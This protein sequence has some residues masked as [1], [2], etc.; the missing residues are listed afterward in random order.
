VVFAALV[1]GYGVLSALIGGAPPADTPLDSQ[2][3]APTGTMALAEILRNRGVTVRAGDDVKA[4]LG[5]TS[6]TAGPARTVVVVKP[7]RLSEATLRRLSSE[8]A[9]GLDLVLVEPDSAVLDAL[10]VPVRTEDESLSDSGSQDPHC[11]LPEADIAGSATIAANTRYGPLDGDTGAT[12][13]FCYRSGPKD[14]ALVVVTPAESAGRIVVLGGSAFLTN[15]HLAQD[16]NA[17][18]ALG[19]LTRHPRLDWVL[20]RRA[21]S[22]PVDG[23]GLA[24]LLGRGFWLTCLQLLIALVLL[25]L[26]RG[27]RLGPPVPEPLPVVVRAAET[28]EGR[29]RLYAAARAHDL[30]AEALRAGLRARLADRLGLPPHGARGAVG[31]I[32]AGAVATEIVGPD[33]AT[34]VVSVAERTGRAPGEIGA[35]LYGSDGPATAPS[36]LEAPG[37]VA[38]P[39]MDDAALLRLTEALDDLERQVGGR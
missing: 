11:P 15:R 21:S 22:A 19:L 39:G 38:P 30:A 6:D 25:A 27:R 37:G 3:P 33:P 16:G 28:T 34:L 23:K 10:A 2:S 14:A 24:D 31:T 29:G 32:R 13:V 1:A 26:W 5:Q 7:G 17:A 35:L 12:A 8:V 4:L 18:L 36:R 9:A 20:Q